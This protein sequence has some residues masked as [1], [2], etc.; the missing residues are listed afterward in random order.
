MSGWLPTPTKALPKW[1]LPVLRWPRKLPKLKLLASYGWAVNLGLMGIIW[2]CAHRLTWDCS[3]IDE[4]AEVTG[5]GLLQA[6]GLEELEG[7][8]RTAE[9]GGPK[10]EDP[11]SRRGGLAI[12]RW[13]RRSRSGRLP[14]GKQPSGKTR[15]TP[16]LAPMW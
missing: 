7:G 10:A 15:S 11:N 3:H 2:W 13:R 5:E 8:G 14:W 12:L 1:L 9:G 16:D 6:S 4:E